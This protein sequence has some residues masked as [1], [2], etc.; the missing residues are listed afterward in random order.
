MVAAAQ[1]TEGKEGWHR[2]VEKP[3]RQRKV[4]V[5]LRLDPEVLAFYR[6]AGKGYQTT[7][8]NVLRA[9]MQAVQKER[10]DV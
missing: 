10:G 6:S 1:S 9:Y 5:G 7:I 8:N 4:S 2:A 3:R